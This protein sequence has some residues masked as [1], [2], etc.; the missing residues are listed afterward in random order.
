MAAEITV[1]SPD[2]GRLEPMVTAAR[3]ELERAG[4]VFAQRPPCSGAAPDPEGSAH[5]Q[6]RPG[7][8]LLAQRSS[9]ALA[10]ARC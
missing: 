2:F 5:R 4:A 8:V 9:G 10:A 7:L 1:D 6:R 3:N